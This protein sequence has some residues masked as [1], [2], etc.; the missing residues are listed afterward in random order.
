MRLASLAVVATLLFAV[1]P[2]IAEHRGEEKVTVD[3]DNSFEDWIDVED[4][5][6]VKAGWWDGAAP[7][8]SGQALESGA[9][10]GYAVPNVTALETEQKTEVH[11]LEIK[12]SGFD[13]GPASRPVQVHVETQ[14]TVV[15]A[16]DVFKVRSGGTSI[17]PDCPQTFAE[18]LYPGE[19]R[20]AW[21]FQTAQQVTESHQRSA[22]VAG[23][24]TANLDMNEAPDGYLVA[25]YP[26][27][28]SGQ[29]TVE[30][31]NG[32]ANITYEVTYNEDDDQA[33]V[34]SGQEYRAPDRPFHTDEWFRTGDTGPLVECVGEGLAI[35]GGIG[36]EDSQVREL[37][38]T[39]PATERVASLMSTS[40][41]DGGST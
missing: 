39:G 37:P 24:M 33:T 6:Y 22:G 26:Q 36:E 14:G 16:M 5:A 2:T 3:E 40:L 35:P 30:S 11:W 41:P 34:R 28:G 8:P 17:T 18:E 1:G 12:R 25:I 27:A 23:N 7:A 9:D 13:P 15:A 20:F 38:G 10:G 4:D 32:E 31:V 21:A 29:D 19:D